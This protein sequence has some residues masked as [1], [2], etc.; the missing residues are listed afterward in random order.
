MKYLLALLVLLNILD[1]VLTHLL[2]SL[3]LASEGNP[4][5]LPLVG[6]PGFIVLKVVGVLLCAFIL[7]DIYRRYPRLALVSTALFNIGYGII[8][9]WNLALLIGS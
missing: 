5:L 7:W 9:S 3:G 8:V 4:F 2:V 1:G 6:E